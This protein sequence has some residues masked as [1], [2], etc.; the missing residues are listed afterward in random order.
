MMHFCSW[1]SLWG[2]NLHPLP[3]VILDG[4]NVHMNDP[5][6]TLVSYDFNCTP[7]FIIKI[8]SPILNK[9][10]TLTISLFV[11]SDCM[12]IFFNTSTTTP[13]LLLSFIRWS[14]FII[15][16]EN[17]N[18]E[19]SATMTYSHV[20]YLVS[21]FQVVNEKLIN[22]LILW[23]YN[24]YMCMFLSKITVQRRTFS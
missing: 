13:F 2:Q 9:A 22:P 8:Q 4:S 12:P 18:Y 10:W 16:R 17:I 19:I 11:W 14:W 20:P 24:V 3:W 23:I 15:N 1:N 6:Y 5:S 21:I 7:P